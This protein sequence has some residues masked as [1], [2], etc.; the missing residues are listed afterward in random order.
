MPGATGVF[1]HRRRRRLPGV[2]RE[3]PF[4]HASITIGQIECPGRL[5]H[6]PYSNGNIAVVGPVAAG[7]VIDCITLSHNLRGSHISGM[8]TLRL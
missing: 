6:L 3:S 2:E 4:R 5:F 7:I 8:A 1:H